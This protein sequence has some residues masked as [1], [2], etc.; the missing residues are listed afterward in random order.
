M[1]KQK[2]LLQLVFSAL[3]FCLIIGGGYLA[4]LLEKI[5]AIDDKIRL[6]MRR[7]NSTASSVAGVPAGRYQTLLALHGSMWPQGD[8]RKLQLVIINTDPY[9]PVMIESVELIDKTGQSVALLVASDTP[10][11]PLA[12]QR[13]ALSISYIH[14]ADAT[15]CV[16]RWR[17]G[18]RLSQPLMQ[19]VLPSPT[20]RLL[21]IKI[22]SAASHT[23]QL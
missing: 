7:G 20:E 21:P 12:S 22:I 15:S 2:L 1:K 5:E 4:N 14:K 11:A 3:V 16:L 10:L 18:N 19:L 13:L 6:E 9:Q 8:S 17:A 23:A